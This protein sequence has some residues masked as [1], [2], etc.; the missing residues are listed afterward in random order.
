VS[1]LLNVSSV[2]KSFGGIQAVKNVSFELDSGEILGL[3]GP[4][5]AGKTT[6]FN[7]I[8]GVYR[9]SSGS[10]LFKQVEVAGMRPHR[11][12]HLGIARTFQIVKPFPSLTVYQNTMLGSRFGKS[13]RILDRRDFSQNAMECLSFIGF[14]G[15]KDLPCETLN[16]GEIKR[17][18]LARALATRPEILLLD[19]VIAGLNPV[20]TEEMMHLIQRIRTERN[21]TILLIEHVMKAIMGVSDRVIVLHHGERIAQGVPREV[22][23]DPKV[24]DAYLGER[25]VS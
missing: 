1:T 19:E 11:I 17:V 16:Y 25:V 6:L 24:I 8:A 23:Q 5:G 7:L 21:I 3:I 20:E 13:D 14:E 18:E 4:N 10:I 22:V 9:P 12:C 15:R 2:S